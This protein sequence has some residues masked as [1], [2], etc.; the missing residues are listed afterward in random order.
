[1]LS[2]RSDSTLTHLWVLAPQIIPF[3]GFWVEFF[4]ATVPYFSSFFGRL[5]GFG[6][7]FAVYLALFY[8]IWGLFRG[9]FV[10][11]GRF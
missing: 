11:F 8:P 2:A 5:G 3:S 4:S 10:L 1:L 7:R 6:V 9:F